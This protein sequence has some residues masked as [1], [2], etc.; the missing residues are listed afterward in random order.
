MRPTPPSASSKRVVVGAVAAR[1]HAGAV[2]R[3][4]LS[5]APLTSTCVASKESASLQ[6]AASARRA[7]PPRVDAAPRSVAVAIESRAQYWVARIDQRSGRPFG[8]NRVTRETTW[9]RP[10]CLDVPLPAAAHATTAL[11]V[12]VAKRETVARAA[13]AAPV[14][15][16]HVSRHGSVDI[17]VDASGGTT[18]HAANAHPFRY[19]MPS[20]VRTQ[21]NG[22]NKRSDHAPAIVRTR[23]PP[24]SRDPAPSVASTTRAVPSAGVRS[25][26][27]AQVYVNRHGSIDVGGG[28]TQKIAPRVAVPMPS[29]PP[30]HPSQEKSTLS[31]ATAAGIEASGAP[32]TRV[33]VARAATAA[34]SSSNGS[35]A[36]ASTTTRMSADVQVASLFTTN[37]LLLSKLAN[38][39]P[40]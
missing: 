11:P 12:A 14:A 33:A 5:A 26:P 22:A 1:A 3:R 9:A 17:R 13:P 32:T 6:A 37:S 34:F 28:A 24:Q 16:V 8:A 2:L 25:S 20:I 18:S 30:V 4:A 7:K 19:T 27:R 21:K 23:A 40:Y 29:A 35:S 39:L 15:K 36:M 31:L 38:D 10:P